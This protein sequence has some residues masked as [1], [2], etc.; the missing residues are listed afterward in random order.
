MGI[1]N[2][3]PDSFSDGGCF[4]S[5]GAAVAHAEKM[6]SEGA[7]ILDIGGESTRPATFENTEPLSE[8]EECHRILPVIQEIARRFPETPL[9]VDT[10][11][12]KVAES[13]LAYGA[14]ML[15]DISAFRADPLMLELAV[16]CQVPTCL[17]HLLGLPKAIPLKPHYEDV[18]AEVKEHLRAQADLAVRAGFA[19]ENIILDPGFG[20][21]KTVQNNL[22]LL[23]RL[24][25]LVELGYPVLMGTSRKSTIGRVLGDLPPQ[26]RLEGTAATVALSIAYGASIVRVHDVKEMARVVKMSVAVI[27]GWEEE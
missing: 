14:V 2:V 24:R 25:E 17:M 20:F 3:T 27:N 23:K 4:D 22:A 11:K 5:L 9:S 26:E 18:V 16:R 13:A 7:D 19:R 8:E 15:N 12:A 6:I 10:Y 1:L 21:G